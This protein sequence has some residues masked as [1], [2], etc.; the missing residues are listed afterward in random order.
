MV[1]IGLLGL[2]ASRVL[3]SLARIKVQAAL[4]AALLFIKVANDRV[5][6]REE[7]KTCSQ[8]GQVKAETHDMSSHGKGDTKQAEQQTAGC[9]PAVPP[10]AATA[11]RRLKAAAPT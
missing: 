3:A 10:A 5:P 7:R 8:R 9:G 1:P 6:K 4:S 2:F 11:C